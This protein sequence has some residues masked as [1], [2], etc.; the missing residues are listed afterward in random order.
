LKKKRGNNEGSIRKRADGRFEA[1]ITLENGKRKSIYKDTR[2]EVAQ[3]MNQ[4][5]HDITEGLPIVEERQR[6]EQYLTIWLETVRYKLKDTSFQRYHQQIHLHILP[7][8]GRVVLAKLTAQQVQSFYAS[9]LKKGLSTTTVQHLHTIFHSALKDAVRLGLLQRNVTDLVHVPRRAHHEMVTLS[10]IDVRRFL[11]AAKGDRYEALY[12]LAI[13]TGIR[14]GEL[15]GLRWEDVN[16]EQAYLV[17]RGS[18]QRVENHF[19]IANPKTSHSRRRI[20]L[21]RNVATALKEHLV[22][23]EEEKQVF[24]IGWDSTY[25]L[26]FPNSL[27]KIMK[28]SN[29]SQGY[30]QRVL[31]KAGL[32]H[33]RFHDL[34]H[35]AATLLLGRGV[36]PKVVSEMLGHSQIS[37]TLDVYSHITP[38]MQ[39]GAA[40]VM[41]NVLDNL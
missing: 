5:H 32:S 38:H 27:G 23:Q 14:L 40:L 29:L 39:E 17:I 33:I 28:P 36:N 20:A 6:L 21:S 10:E 26:V 2:Q 18:V 15:L 35:T 9:L 34:R 31:K 8:L 25:N 11:I 41:D 37:I 19:T 24:G 7:T 13:S 3:V 12:V 30:F 1:R 16:F 4:A 22:R